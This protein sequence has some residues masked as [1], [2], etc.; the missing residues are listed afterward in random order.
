MFGAG[1]LTDVV[2]LVKVADHTVAGTTTITSASVDMA[3]DGGW[4]GV[5]FFT[6]YGTA[7]ANNILKAEQSE[8]D[9]S[10][11]ELADNIPSGTSDEDVVLDIQRPRERF[12]RASGVRGTSSTLESIWAL[13]YR[14][15]NRKVTN[16]L[17]GTLAL[18]QSSSPAE[19]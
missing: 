13:R 6:S 4:D 7:N 9:S 8:D 19:V 1:F 10:F 2:K 18:K 3:Q 16:A 11:A 15:R 12:V 5:V 17:S 14:S